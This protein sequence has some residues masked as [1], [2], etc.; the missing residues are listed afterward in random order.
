MRIALVNGSPKR[1]NSASAF[2]LKE[3]SEKLA[4]CVCTEISLHARG[5]ATD[6]V[7]SALLE[8]DA[9]ALAFP[10]YVDGVP[11]HLLAELCEMQRLLAGR[12]PLSVYAM[13]NC[14]FFEGQQAKVALRIVENWCA[15]CG[16]G[17]CGGIGIGGGGMLLS[18]RNVPP[19]Y[20]PRKPVS[21]AIS[22]L[23]EMIRENQTMN[24]Q[25]V[26]PAFPRLLYKLAAQ[27]GW[28]EKIRKNGL[29]SKDLSRRL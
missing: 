9:L 20:G 21:E 24:N 26:S 13:V 18:L 3:L 19:G 5:T 14:G 25:F 22:C 6:A 15:R 7:E 12:K 8:A 11:S 17:W 1:K 28:R 16:F 23:S 27:S 4:D 10:L 29:R 2:L